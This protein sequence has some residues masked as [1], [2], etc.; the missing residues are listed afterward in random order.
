[1]RVIVVRPRFIKDRIKCFKA[2]L[3]VHEYEAVEK[4]VKQEEENIQ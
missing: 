2:T 1:M 3:K 4:S